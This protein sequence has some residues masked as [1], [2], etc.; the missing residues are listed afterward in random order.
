M[1]HNVASESKGV[2]S[3]SASVSNEAARD[4]RVSGDCEFF[5][6]ETATSTNRM[7]F[8]FRRI[9]S[10]PVRSR[11]SGHL[12]ELDQV[13]RRIF[14]TTDILSGEKLAAVRFLAGPV[15]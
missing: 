12:P 4:Y 6:R 15:S 1:R 10:F 8:G 9:Y 7:R 13:L 2:V 5:E 3:F 11:D 14:S